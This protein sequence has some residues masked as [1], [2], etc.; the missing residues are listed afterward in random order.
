MYPNACWYAVAWS[1][2][3]M[4]EA[5]FFIKLIEGRVWALV[6]FELRISI[7]YVDCEKI[8]KLWR[9]ELGK[10]YTL[11]T[12]SMMDSSLEPANFRIDKKAAI[13]ILSEPVD[14]RS[15]HF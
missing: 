10:R 14:H 6:D 2:Q 9:I 5:E 8:R 12:V 3:K 11:R 4:S 1:A 15:K 13:R 7:I